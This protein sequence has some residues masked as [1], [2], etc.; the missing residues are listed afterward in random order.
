MS[1]LIMDIETI[2][3]KGLDEVVEA[4]VAKRT[5]RRLEQS[6]GDS[7]EAESL[8][9]STSPFFGEVVCVGM[10]WLKGDGTHRDNVICESSEHRTLERFFD[11]VNHESAQSVRFVHY[12][13][14]GFD[15]PFLIVRAAHHGTKITNKKFTDLRRFSYKSHIDLMQFLANWDF[16]GRVSFDIACRS[17]GIPSPKE[18]KV[19]GATV[20]KAFK[21]GN[22]EGIKQYAMEDVEA[23]HKL[24]E[25]LRD[26]IS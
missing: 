10:R 9:R 26:Y 23:T 21:E 8:I 5:E 1:Y 11:V 4:E 18:G 22:L 20:G 17:F 16:R 19:T 24:F 12:N 15:I 2:P 25:K 3:Q 6:G 14:L 7:A 13:G